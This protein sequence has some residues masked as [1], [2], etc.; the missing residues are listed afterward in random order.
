MK[1]HLPLSL[2]AALLSLFFLP[3]A[4]AG[5]FEYTSPD[6]YYYMSNGTHSDTGTCNAYQKS[7]WKDAGSSTITNAQGTKTTYDNYYVFDYALVYNLH[8]YH[9]CY[10]DESGSRVSSGGCDYIFTGVT[11]GNGQNLTWTCSTDE[12]PGV[13]ILSSSKRTGTNNAAVFRN[14]GDMVV[15]GSRQQYYLATASGYDENGNV[16][17]TKTLKNFSDAAIYATEGTNA[18]ASFI[19]AVSFD[20]LV[21]N[22]GSFTFQNGYTGG[23]GVLVHTA[24]FVTFNNVGS[25]NFNNNTAEGSGILRDTDFTVSVAD[26]VT[27]SNNAGNGAAIAYNGERTPNLFCISDVKG[28]VVFSGNTA[29]NLFYNYSTNFTDIGSVSF[30]NNSGRIYK[31]YNCT[32]T[33]VFTNVGALTISGNTATEALI[34]DT[35]KGSSVVSFVNCGDIS[36]ADNTYGNF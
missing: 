30:I 24:Q 10:I 21:E 26:N 2:R 7:M 19:G 17:Y 6:Y 29:T 31:G 13:W 27:F 11:D 22:T 16:I 4:Q 35:N 3:T 32:V 20:L 34:Y 5:S 25:I 8:S 12:T 9:N 1:L 18:N 28:A 15:D 14:Y 23:D 33:P 36:I